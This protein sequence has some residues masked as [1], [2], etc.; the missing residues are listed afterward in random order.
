MLWRRFGTSHVLNLPCQTSLQIERQHDHDE[1]Q[2]WL[3]QHGGDNLLPSAMQLSIQPTQDINNAK[4][5]A[6]KVL[7]EIGAFAQ[8]QG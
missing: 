7:H 8:Q 3:R 5:N 6:L 4:E 1:W 2:A